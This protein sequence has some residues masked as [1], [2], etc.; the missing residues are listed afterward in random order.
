MSNL[1]LHSVYILIKFHKKARLRDPTD[2]SPSFTSDYEPP[3]L[4]SS[5][6]PRCLTTKEHQGFQNPDKLHEKQ[7]ILSPHT[8]NSVKYKVIGY[9]K[10]RDKS[11]QYDVLF[12][13]C[14]DLI[15]LNV[16]EV[17]KML[18]DSL[19]IPTSN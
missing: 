8:N 5:V 16:E 12:D 14:G 11:V 4:K 2:P 13:D 6:E 7:F 15:L 9:H 18:E 3:L 1:V 10:K 17:M 19:Y